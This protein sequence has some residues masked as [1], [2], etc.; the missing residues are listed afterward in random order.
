MR[1]RLVALVLLFM[2]AL[3]VTG[4]AGAQVSTNY[5]LSWH[6]IAGAG[7]EMASAGHQVRSTLGQLSIGPADSAGHHVGAGYWYGVWREEE[8]H[9]IYLPLVMRS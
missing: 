5:D 9:R 4:I 6:V 1:Q 8:P 2:I 7:S 3:L